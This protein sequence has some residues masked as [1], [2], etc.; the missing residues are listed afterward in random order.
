MAW[1]VL[2]GLMG[3]CSGG[4]SITSGNGGGPVPE[5][6]FAIDGNANTV[7]V[8]T[9]D[10]TI[11]TWTP[12]GTIATGTKPLAV[13]LHPSGKFLY[14]ANFNSANISAY[15]IDPTTG[16][17][18]AMMGSPFAAVNAP[19]ALAIDS[20][21]N[22]L[23]VSTL[24][25]AMPPVHVLSGYSINA[26]TG[27]LT[28]IA[29]PNVP[30]DTTPVGLTFAPTTEFLYAADMNNNVLGFSAHAATGVLA[31]VPGNPFAAGTMPF[32]IVAH[33]TGKFVYVTNII[34]G[35]VSGYL[36]DALTGRLTPV[37]MS[38]FTSGTSPGPIPAT[39][40]VEPTGKFLYVV[41]A[42]EADI[43]EYSIDATS[44][45]LAPL[46]TSPFVLP[47]GTILLRMAVDP[48]GTFLYV[49]NFSGNNI[50]IFMIQSNG[51]LNPMG[52]TLMGAGATSGIAFRAGHP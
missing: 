22:F 50:S 32:G 41:N 7:S 33:P 28:L 19:Q 17:L 2:S 39:I 42:G 13:A 36:V 3:G 23:Y 44:G 48:T 37:P 1:I 26:T 34:S 31:P 9:V 25:A 5:V 45:A 11:G 12:I 30:A 8:F 21:G 4:G 24:T 47:A 27:A 43:S 18:T 15:N 52:T 10:T 29:Q 35:D 14:V 20:S 49:V 16:A 40:A 38:P 6:A 46:T 51:S